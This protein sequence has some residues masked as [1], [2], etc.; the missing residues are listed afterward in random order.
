MERHRVYKTMQRTPR[1]FGMDRVI[2]IQFLTSLSFSVFGP[3]ILFGT[4]SFALIIIFAS[5]PINVMVFRKRDK[6]NKKH[7]F[8]KKRL[9]KWKPSVIREGYPVILTVHESFF[10]K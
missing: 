7:C 5:F 4:S 6:K 2:A 9:N 1:M 10:D 3:L 8:K